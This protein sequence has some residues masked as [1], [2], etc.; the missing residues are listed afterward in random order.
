[1]AKIP[2]HIITGFLGSGK[3][4]FLKELLS[5]EKQDNIAIIVNELGQISLDHSILDADFIKEKTLFLNSGCM[6]C[7][8]REDLIQKL[9]NLLDNYDKKSQILQRVIIETTGLAN[10]APIIFTFLSDAFLFHH[11]E[12]SNII[13]CIDALNGLD[14]IENNE[15]AYNQIASSDCILMT[16][17]DLNANTQILNEKINS[18]HQGI[19]IIKKENFT[20]NTLLNTKRQEI[21]FNKTPNKNFHNKNIQS[22]CISFKKAID[23]SIFGIWLS[24]L[25]HQYG[26][27]ILRVKGLLDIGEDFLVNINGVG[28]IIHP[29]THIKNTRDKES[30]LVFITKNLDPLKIISSLE[31]FLALSK[32]KIEF[33]IN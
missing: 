29:P 21:F 4:T 24:M 18:I 32:E 11:F 20:F 27:Q 8:K 14:H 3:T 17:N 2:I 28:H 10:P 25:L 33:I 19:N 16:K 30:K 1:M 13:T 26:T 31:S 9:R 12:I 5:K 7:N 6:C 15:E 23:W 22:I